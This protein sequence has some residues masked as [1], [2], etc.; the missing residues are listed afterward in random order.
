M[1]TQNSNRHE[2]EKQNGPNY[3]NQLQ[4]LPQIV[5]QDAGNIKNMSSGKT[6]ILAFRV[7][8]MIKSGIKPSK[9]MVL[10]FGKLHSQVF[11]YKLSQIIDNQAQIN[12]ILSY[13]NYH[14]NAFQTELSE[15]GINDVIYSSINDVSLSKDRKN[16]DWD[17]QVSLCTFHRSQGMGWENVFII[18]CN[19]EINHGK[20][21][22]NEMQQLK[23]A[24][25]LA[26]TRCS[27]DLHISIINNELFLKQKKNN[28]MAC[29]YKKCSRVISN[30]VKNH[31]DLF[32]MNKL[33]KY[34]GV[35]QYKE[36]KQIP[37]NKIETNAQDIIIKFTYENFDDLRQNGL[38]QKKRIQY[39][40]LSNGNQENMKLDSQITDNKFESYWAY[41]LKLVV[42]E[43]FL[44][45]INI[46]NIQ[47]LDVY[48]DKIIN[49]KYEFENLNKTNKIDKQKLK[50]VYQ[51]YSQNFL[52][53]KQDFDQIYDILMPYIY[54]Y[55]QNRLFFQKNKET[56]K[57][58]FKK[59]LFETG[60]TPLYDKI[61]NSIEKLTDGQLITESD[62]KYQYCIV[63]YQYQFECQIDLVIKDTIIM[64]KSEKYTL[65][66]ILELKY[67][68]AL[69]M[70]KHLGSIDLEVDQ[71]KKQEMLEKYTIKNIIIFDAFKQQ[72]Y[73]YNIDGFYSYIDEYL[74]Y[75]YSV[76][77][78][79]YHCSN[80]K[81][82]KFSFF[83]QKYCQP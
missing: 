34:S 33:L 15:R 74:Q 24:M 32:K 46:K 14:L 22:D 79:Q 40:N 83:Y 43:L 20:N 44:Q 25:Y 11:K 68:A 62:I 21:T 17:N 16:G 35:F 45:K 48:A 75:L 41:F 50:E 8:Q 66:D 72:C 1:V 26:V 82:G 29:Y 4:N 52:N 42:I 55:F 56:T 53:I 71:Q 27:K 7:L 58:K 65:E 47:K 12:A 78:S 57:Y 67:W 80:T 59:Q 69:Y 49:E 81:G 28:Q 36:N 9:I 76:R 60:Q 64:I 13:Q 30:V 3:Y 77:E 51:N 39:K 5:Q 61:V 31:E 70:K 54:I 63:N 73:T 37:D 6:T 38:L 23:N 18:S 19:D 2:E 10:T